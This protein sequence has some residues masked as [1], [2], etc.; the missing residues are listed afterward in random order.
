MMQIVE[1]S[2]EGF[3]D[4]FAQRSARNAVDLG[5]EPLV[6]QILEDVN[7]RGDTAVAYWTQKLD[8]E[9][10]RPDDMEIVPD[11]G[12]IE[13]LDPDLRSA[14]ETA[15]A[16]IRAFHERLMPTGWYE[17]T[18]PGIK[19]GARITPLDR[20][21]IYV[22]GGKAAYPSSIL[23][24]AIPASVAGVE[25]VVMVTPPRGRHL[26]LVIEAAAAM[27]GVHRI[28]RV[29]G[30]Q[31]IAALA[32]GTERIPRVDKVVGPGNRFV[33]EAKR[34]VY[35]LVDIDSVAGPSEVCIIADGSV[36]PAWAAA[37]AL[38]QAEHDEAAA[39]LILVTSRDYGQQI[40]DAIPG[41]LQDN[42]R[43]DIAAAS[44]ETN[45]LVVVCDGLDQAVDLSNQYAPEHLELLVDDP[46]ALLERLRHAGAIFIGASTPEAVG[47]YIAGPNHVLPT[48]GTARFYSPLGTG[49]FVKRTSLMSFNQ[50][51]LARYAGSIA[52]LA[53]E[54]GLHAHRESV[55]IR[56]K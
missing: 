48:Q 12:C 10:I 52:R 46:E 37:D 20:V 4:L 53:D 30:A 8:G 6:E 35:G 38:A 49:D 19:L 5:G 32:F 33:A 18:E 41:L 50:D 7:R 23:M 42:P 26:P 28:F 51:A 36:D 25:E 2:Q 3:T 55:L 9:V 29:G 1:T 31:A 40:I 39:V 11:P 34:R 45:G 47:D 43:R 15:A 22:P 27:A 54:E 44:L 14:L 16:R 24:C 56:S 21:G 17:T 13:K